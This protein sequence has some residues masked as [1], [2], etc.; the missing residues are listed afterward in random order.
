M[1]S[2]LGKERPLSRCFYGLTDTVVRAFA[3]DLHVM[4]VIII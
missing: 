3:G 1:A 2:S 4:L